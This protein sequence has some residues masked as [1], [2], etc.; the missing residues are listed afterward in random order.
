V[1]PDQIHDFINEII[2]RSGLLTKASDEDLYAYAHRAF[3]EHFLAMQLARDPSTGADFLLN[4][5]AQSEWQQTIVFFCGRDNPVAVSF[6]RSLADHNL[7]LAL[8]CLPVAI[9][10]DDLGTVL[11]GRARNKLSAASAGSDERISLLAGLVQ[12]THSPSAHVRDLAFDDLQAHLINLQ[13]SGDAATQRRVLRALFG[14]EVPAATRLLQ[15]LSEKATTDV[16]VAIAYLALVMPDDDPALVAPLWRCLAA[17]ELAQSAASRTIVRRLIA[18]AMDPACF[19]ELQRQPPL[20]LRWVPASHR[21]SVYPLR[22]GLPLDSN[23][24]TL[25]GC[26]Y[27]LKAM[28]DLL[29]RNAYLQALDAPGNPLH[30]LERRQSLAGRVRLSTVAKVSATGVLGIAL[31]G[32]LAAPFSTRPLLDPV[33]WT[34]ALG[35]HLTA[36]WLIGTLTA[37]ALS[38]YEAHGYYAPFTPLVYLIPVDSSPSAFKVPS[39]LRLTRL[40]LRLRDPIVGLLTRIGL[41]IASVPVSMIYALPILIWLPG[42][43]WL[44]ATVAFVVIIC[45]FWI[46]ATELC[47]E[48]GPYSLRLSYL[49]QTI[50]DDPRS[51]HWVITGQVRESRLAI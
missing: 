47:G 27:T 23:L 44:A 51:R 8:H 5:Q 17:P 42:P 34:W 3:H 20:D 31:L 39:M 45:F 18:L 15:Y 38:A 50:Y 9:V 16:G 30:Q 28:D 40:L 10:S 7:G 48:F 2:D 25:L 41:V 46:P 1:R 35:V 13:A 22:K 14:G 21:R 26:A 43:Q 37:Q 36:T 19:A 32:L 11:I 49:Y 29:E 33:T 6:I 24:V 4:R 12:A